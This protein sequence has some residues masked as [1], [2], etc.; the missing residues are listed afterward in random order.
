[1]TSYA[2]NRM[3]GRRDSLG[4][5]PGPTDQQEFLLPDGELD[6][7]QQ[8][9]D[10]SILE[11]HHRNTNLAPTLPSVNSQTPEKAVSA[12]IWR[13]QMLN[14]AWWWW[15]IASSALSIISLGLSVYLL[16]QINRLPLN[17]WPFLIQPN[18]LL[19][20][21]MT[22]GK[23]SMLVPIASCISQLKWHHFLTQ[24]RCL[25]HLQLF[26]SASR[27]PWGASMF[28][29]SLR[30][31]AITAYAL[32]LVT[33]ISLAI[34]PSTQ[35]IIHVLSREAPLNNVTATIGRAD[36]YTSKGL[37]VD[38]DHW[39]NFFSIATALLNGAAGTIGRP[40]LNCP[41]P[42]FRCTYDDFTILG[43]CAYMINMTEHTT[44]SCHGS[45]GSYTYINC[46]YE[47]PNQSVYT[48]DSLSLTYNIAGDKSEVGVPGHT[49]TG[50]SPAT[51]TT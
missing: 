13:N 21:F 28:L 15:E 48:G 7:R 16:S 44:S 2:N 39:Q 36:S 14:S 23:G 4:A 11:N 18:S 43:F 27:G 35:Q 17:E 8:S 26:D 33:I 38:S 19:S 3:V 46:T 41:S 49:L 34:D 10:T 50:Q 45:S 31:P 32:A 25:H 12:T 6:E 40:S 51:T 29:Y 24:E 47:F 42:A 5:G 9:V 20:I 37:S 22:V 1:M 30:A